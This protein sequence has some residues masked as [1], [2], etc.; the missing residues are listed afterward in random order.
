M[1]GIATP[2]DPE[3]DDDD[4]NNGGSTQK[5]VTDNN[6]GHNNNK[7]GTALTSQPRDS[8]AAA[9]GVGTAAGKEAAATEGAGDSTA[10]VAGA[11]SDVTVV[12]AAKSCGKKNRTAECSNGSGKG[13]KGGKGVVELSVAEAP[14]EGKV[15]FCVG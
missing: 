8:Q 2:F 7:V 10:G 6:N 12:S 3:D 13:V 14:V 11:S 5:E 1:P 15:S 4:D 9:G